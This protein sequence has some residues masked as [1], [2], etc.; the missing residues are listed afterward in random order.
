MKLLSVLALFALGSSIAAGQLDRTLTRNDVQ[1]LQG[2]WQVESMNGFGQDLVK[3]EMK[4]LRLT[5]RGEKMTA[6]YGEKKAEA[7]FKVQFDKEPAQIDITLTKT[8][9]D[10]KELVG[11]TFRGILMA[12]GKTLKIAYRSPDEK[13]PTSFRTEGEPG[14]Y[15]V[16]F[17]RA[18][19]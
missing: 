14:V 5:I 19:P 8:P 17:K 9:E 15:V 16:V 2:T 11:K 1:S 13:R 6:E 7:T 3:D 12:D 18:Q 4:S 10:A